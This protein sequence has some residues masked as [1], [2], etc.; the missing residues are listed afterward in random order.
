MVSLL[1]NRRA[2][3][4][5]ALIVPVAGCQELS[6]VVMPRRTTGLAPRVDRMIIML[7]RSGR[8]AMM[9]PEPFAM[10]GLSNGGRDVPS[11]Q[12]AED[13][14]DGRYVLSLIGFRS[15]HEF[16]FHRRQG[17]GQSEVLVFHHV[18]GAFTRLASVRYART[19][20]PQPLS[21]VA[22]ADSD[23]QQQLSFWLARVPGR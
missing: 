10:M 4:S 9:A 18:D 21:D 6:Q 7:Q 11:K 22:I 17:E 3:L 13:G 8:D 12:M 2:F 14:P 5:A 16:V 15:L 19:G 1:A 23:F 20:K